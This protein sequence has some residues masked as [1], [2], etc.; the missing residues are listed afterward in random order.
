MSESPE[1]GKQVA[2]SVVCITHDFFVMSSCTTQLLGQYRLHQNPSD[3]GFVKA[4]VKQVVQQEFALVLSMSQVAQ[5]MESIFLLETYS[6]R[7]D[8]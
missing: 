2:S 8:V 4:D 1:I 5:L 3:W 7:G 6:R